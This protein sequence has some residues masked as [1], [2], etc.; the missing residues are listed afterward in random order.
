MVRAF[1]K[2]PE[3]GMSA[4]AARAEAQRIESTRHCV[5]G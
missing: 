3:M 2:S 5:A 4:Q 1:S